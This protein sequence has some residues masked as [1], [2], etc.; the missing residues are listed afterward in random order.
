MILETILTTTKEAK[1]Q[2]SNFKLELITEEKLIPL[3]KGINLAL[4]FNHV[5]KT[6]N[7]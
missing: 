2:N 3:Q 6:N 7:A 4:V 5:K 1:T